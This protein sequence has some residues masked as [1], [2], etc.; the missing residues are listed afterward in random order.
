MI[1]K[2]KKM[3]T[4][5]RSFTL[6]ELLVVIAIIAILASML[7]PA[8]NQAKGKARTITCTNNLKQVG[9]GFVMYRNDFED[10]FPWVFGPVTNTS[11]NSFLTWSWALWNNNYLPPAYVSGTGGKVVD[12][13]SP[14]FCPESVPEMQAFASVSSGQVDEL[15]K[16]GK[17][18]SYPYQ[19]QTGR[20]GLGG[21]A[22]FNNPPVKSSQISN[23]SGVMNLIESGTNNPRGNSILKTLPSFPTAM[24]RH[25]GVGR[26]T[27]LLFVDGHVEYFPNGMQLLTWWTDYNGKQKQYPFNTDLK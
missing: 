8:L 24:G 27:N 23:P 5:T 17:S 6:I 19:S 26:G 3:S 16:W 20:Y 10:Y 18:Y 13:D 2:E 1:T 21:S 9:T 12:F 25:G 11:W 22:G 14:W 4:R 7:L 15:V